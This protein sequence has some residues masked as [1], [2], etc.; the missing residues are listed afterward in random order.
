M[1]ILYNIYSNVHVIMNVQLSGMTNMYF[2][3]IYVSFR[4]YNQH[5]SN[6]HICVNV[7]VYTFFYM[8]I[9]LCMYICVHVCV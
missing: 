3:S 9:D 7:S 2:L 6:E 1:N 5:Q 8:N 4:A